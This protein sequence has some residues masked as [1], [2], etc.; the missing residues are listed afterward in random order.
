MPKATLTVAIDQV[1]EASAVDAWFAKWGPRLSYRSDNKGC[2]CCVDIW[3]I[4]GPEDAVRE[5][6]GEVLTSDDW[7]AGE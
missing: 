7:S 5:I 2:G 6:P 4:E 3:Q 1:G